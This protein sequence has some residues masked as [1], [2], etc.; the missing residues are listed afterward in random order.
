VNA[1]PGS[2]RLAA[3]LAADVVGY[4][5]LIGADEPGTLAKLAA[6]R[7]TVIDPQMAT[8]GG[9]VFKTTGDGLLAEF[10]SGVQA[11]QC[12][13]AIQQAMRAQEGIQLR[14][15]L[16]SADVTVQPDGDLLG[17]G[18]NVAA[19]LEALAEPG[20]ICISG[21]VREDAAGKLALEVEDLGEPE[22]KNI[23]QRHRVFRV[24]LGAPEQPALPLPDKPSLAVLP[25]QNMSGDPEQEYFV[26]GLVEDITTALSRAGWLFVV[27]RNSSFTYK[28]RAVDMKQVGR[29]LGVRYVLEGSIRR[30]GA[31]VRIT[32]QLI[33]TASGGHVWADRFDGEFADIFELQDRITESV[34]GAIEPSV[35][36]AEITRALAKPTESLDAY[37][38]YLR[39]LHGY[40]TM[41]RDSIDAAIRLLRRALEIDS[42]YARARALMAYV[43]TDRWTA[44][45]S[46]PGDDEIALAQARDAIEATDDDPVT[47]CMA[48]MALAFFGLDHEGALTAL[49][50]ALELH[51]NYPTALCWMGWVQTLMGDHEAAAECC[52]RAMRISPRDQERYV[53]LGILALAHLGAGRNAEAETAAQ[54][55]VQ[56]HPRS[57]PE[58]RFLILAL[59]R[60]GRIDEAR[61][62]AARLLEINPSARISNMRI[63]SRNR[64][65]VEEFRDA[66]RAAGMPE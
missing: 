55:S 66:L 35:R 10:A 32:G 58:H 23:T 40:Y 33:D 6:L 2:R 49:K 4:S 60:L 15:G 1:E 47:L 30:A 51:P 50:R 5:R 39:A 38:L 37:D 36:R 63:P 3:I 64:A 46:E 65:F 7:S 26:D 62:A 11:V 43:Y 48:G 53:F 8:H 14:I 28:G 57:V 34:V 19:R 25:F 41:T 56:G 52:R 22:L 18:V 59:V 21:R 44:G 12:A 24:R 16:H 17:D 42:H 9:R 13:I 61:A 45:W 31:R 20:G 27:A 54:Q 29:E